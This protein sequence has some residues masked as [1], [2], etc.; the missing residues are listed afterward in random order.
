MSAPLS[1]KSKH[2]LAGPGVRRHWGGWV[3]VGF[4]VL[5]LIS[6]L[7]VVA[8]LYLLV[9][10]QNMANSTLQ[11]VHDNG[12]WAAFQIER[13]N[14]RFFY[15][16]TRHANNEA[17]SANQPPPSWA[18]VQIRFDI[19]YSRMVSLESSPINSFSGESNLVEQNAQK[20]NRLIA[21][22][23]AIMQ[24][25]R[26]PVLE[27]MEVMQR[28]SEQLR[29]LA[30]NMLLEIVEYRGEH[31][32]EVRQRQL[33]IYRQITFLVLLL[34][35]AVAAF[36]A[37]LL[38]QMTTVQR[39]YKR[40][41]EL[42]AQLQASA[43]F[44]EDASRSKS[45]FL[46]NMSH[47]IRTPMNAILGML[48]LLQGTGL[49]ERQADYVNKAGSAAR[50][51]LGILNDI[52]DFSKVEADKLVLDPQPF[53][54][55][56]VLRELST[57]MSNNLGK[58]R[59]ELLFDIDP[60]VPR[61][62]VGDALRLKQVL[63]N[64]A[65]NAIKFTPQGEVRLSV[66][67]LSS[68]Q[69]TARLGFGVSDTGI[70]ISA[71]Q[72]ARIFDG[73]S[74]A[75]ASTSRRYGGTGLGLAI[76]RRLVGLMGGELKLESQPGLGS[77]FA[78]TLELPV[79]AK[80]GADAEQEHPSLS[81]MHVLV[82]AHAQGTR[83][84]LARMATE[85]GWVVE[86]TTNGETALARLADWKTR[87]EPCDIVLVDW[88]LPDL[89]GWTTAQRV[90][91]TGYPLVVMVTSNPQEM[92]EGRSAEEVAETG[93]FLVKPFTR[94][95]VFETIMARRNEL[96]S[97]QNE[98]ENATTANQNK[99]LYGLRL[100]V[101]EDNPINQQVAQELLSGAGARVSLAENGNEGVQAVRDALEP[102]DLVLM[103]MQMP[104]MDGL[105]ATRAI[106]KEL[107]QSTL[108]I[109]AMTANAMPADREACFAAGMNDHV[110]KPFDITELVS[111]IA[112]YCAH[113]LASIGP[114]P[115]SV[116]NGGS[117]RNKPDLFARALELDTPNNT[118]LQINEALTRLGGD[119]ALYTK[120]LQG[121]LRDAPRMMDRIHKALQTASE[122][123]ATAEAQQTALHAAAQE[124]HGLKGLSAT[125]GATL[126]AQTVAQVEQR[127]KAVNPHS[128]TLQNREND[129]QLLEH[130]FERV[131]QA[132]TQMLANQAVNLG[133]EPI[134]QQAL[135]TELVSQD[136][137][138]LQQLLLNA[139]MASLDWYEHVLKT[140]GAAAH[141]LLEELD[142]PMD[143]L[144][145]AAA[146]HAVAQVLDRLG[147]ATKGREPA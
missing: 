12:Q 48:Q 94:S 93:S 45:Q 7:L 97:G 131:L 89:D 34:T 76:S 146:S 116:A 133:T 83:E 143:T 80:K 138:H 114:A 54:L 38:R 41:D 28:L 147:G 63:I 36:V 132:A 33:S 109:V 99:P 123:Q 126:Y 15:T 108:P 42:A 88:L 2:V 19:L 75:E 106:R 118:P 14:S 145:F 30:E 31:I 124:L 121:Y 59:L 1:D 101:V 24:L 115:A 122:P 127:V 98:T 52:L 139:D 111:L 107:G 25:G 130:G 141:A 129:Y 73:F 61:V 142:A 117:K 104:V 68:T 49:K 17:G 10:L 20:I 32:T 100:L 58:K 70:G 22:M 44:A 134:V 66:K 6:T 8:A 135:N 64:L 16:L 60:A 84:L 77:R 144:D 23:D 57:I 51:L 55:N 91:A 9:V 102:F 82:V 120:I 4:V 27:R 87:Q 110:G 95:M 65:G 46:A 90:R 140:H 137:Q 96:R 85:L 50:S 53:S 62:L 67:L 35:G 18:D 136:L 5:P 128:G 71:E 29:T 92:L 21:E 43:R 119:L 81:A 113:R 79:P 103:D 47:E 13:E 112:R 26:G 105:Q 3:R 11:A 125:V 39:A 56:Q 74:Q 72:Q 40:V 78:F 37:L 86:T 69:N